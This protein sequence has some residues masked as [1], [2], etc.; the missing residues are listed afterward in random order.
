MCGMVSEVVPEADGSLALPATRFPAYLSGIHGLRVPPHSSLVTRHS[1]LD[2]PSPIVLRP[3]L[4][5]DGF[6][7][8]AGKTLAV[9]KGDTGRARIEVWNFSDTERTG[10]VEAVGVSVSGLPAEPFSIAPGA[11]A[12]FPCEVAPD[13]AEDQAVL[14]LRGVF[15]G[16]ADARAVVPVFFEKRFLATCERVPMETA[17]PSFWK[18]NSSAAEQTIVLDEAENAI[19]FTA[20]WNDDLTDRWLYP[21]HRLDLPRESPVGVRRIVFEVKSEQDKVEN[22]Y[23]T[24]KLMLASDDGN[25]DIYLDYDPPTREWETR[26]VDVPQDADLSAVT[27]LRIGANP[28]GSRLT[29]WVRNILLLKPTSQTS[30]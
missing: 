17:D 6:T 30:P 3:V 4:D 21:I 15:D 9:M 29:L 26:Y 28:L 8:S 10:R 5:T 1:S 2:S 25:T 20:A 13:A 23:K 24:C 16:C 22:D 14:S 18:T 7:I 11:C 12:V 27:L 19:R